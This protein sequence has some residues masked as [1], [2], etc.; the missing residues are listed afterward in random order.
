M[1]LDLKL[2]ENLGWG[3]VTHIIP[4]DQ[5]GFFDHQVTIN[6]ETFKNDIQLWKRNASALLWKWEQYLNVLLT[7]VVSKLSVYL[8]T[9][10][11]C[12]INLY[13]T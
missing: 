11:I 8:W 6:C 7:K 1:D 4:V 5:P 10:Q 3:D 9:V 2:T 12:V 13:L